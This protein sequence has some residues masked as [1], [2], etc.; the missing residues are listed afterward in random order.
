MTHLA[1]SLSKQAVDMPTAAI[2]VFQLAS[3]DWSELGPGAP[4]GL[5]EYMRPK[6]L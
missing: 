1:S 5:V 6:A 2:A 3:H 4:I